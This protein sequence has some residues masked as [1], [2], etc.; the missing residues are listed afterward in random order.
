M[1]ANIKL[2]AAETKDLKQQH[3]LLP[4]AC[5]PT[6]PW[7]SECCDPITQSLF[8]LLSPAPFSQ[9]SKESLLWNKHLS[10]TFSFAFPAFH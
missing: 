8:S 4:Q 5:N 7:R 2:C 6:H 9:A 1:K 10:S 3:S